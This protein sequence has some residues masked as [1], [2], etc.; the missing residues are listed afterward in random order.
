MNCF[1]QLVSRTPRLLSLEARNPRNVCCW[2]SVEYCPGAM[3]LRS[4]GGPGGSAIS[5]LKKTRTLE[6]IIKCDKK[7]NGRFSAPEH[8]SLLNLI[9]LIS[10]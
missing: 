4:S 9:M 3:S 2:A 6:P 10:L 8:R 1:N 5:L 7:N